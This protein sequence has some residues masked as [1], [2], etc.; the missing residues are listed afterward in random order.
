MLWA[1]EGSWRHGLFLQFRHPALRFSEVGRRWVHAR[2]VEGLVGV[3]LAAGGL[4]GKAGHADVRA[5][6]VV[7]ARLR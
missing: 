7:Q 3:L 4:G 2:G 6:A 1:S 5:C